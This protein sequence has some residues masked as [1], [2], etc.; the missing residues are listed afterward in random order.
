MDQFT[1]HIDRGWDLVHRGDLAGAQVSAEQSLELDSQ[2]P[3]AHNLLGYVKAA[4]GQAEDAIELYRQAIALDD[5][6]VEAMLNAAEVLI[7]PLHDFEAA[8]GMI[9]EALD[10]AENDD[11]TAD[12]LLLK[13]DAYVHQGDKVGAQRVVATFPKGPFESPRLDFLIGRAHFETGEQAIAQRLLEHAI[14]REPDYG[15]AHYTLGLL[16]ETRGETRAMVSAFL[17]ARDADLAVAP[18]PFSPTRSAFEELVRAAIARLPKPMLEPLDGADLIVSDLPGAEVIADGV[19]P[20][21]CLLLD[22]AERGTEPRA[23][24]RV[25]RIFFY[26]RNTE[27][28]IEEVGALADEIYVVLEDELCATFPDLARYAT[29]T[30]DEIDGTN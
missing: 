9:D 21:V 17:R 4:Q 2:S 24:T 14:E 28:T 22:T 12:A 1:A 6:F 5:T 18:A 8:L 30:Q 26:Q 29:R 7:H 27:R 16:F 25:T 23:D 15:D 19:D 20:R 10:F 13:Y 3:E 11:E